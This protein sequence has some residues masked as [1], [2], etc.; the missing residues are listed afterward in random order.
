MA[1][2]SHFGSNG[3][4]WWSTTHYRGSMPGEFKMRGDRRCEDPDVNPKNDH[5][6][7]IGRRDAVNGHDPVA[8][9]KFTV[10][11]RFDT[12][13]SGSGSA[14]GASAPVQA[15]GTAVDAKA[16]VD[17]SR[18]GAIIAALQQLLD[19]AEAQLRAIE[20]G[21]AEANLTIAVPAIR[22]PAAPSGGWEVSVRW[23]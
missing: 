22:R 23:E 17:L 11:L 1:G 21:A 10:S 14:A 9:D 6:L 18:K 3:S 15:G 16:M 13:D 12:V 2:E 5:W 4:V 19:D 20:A 8:N 7:D